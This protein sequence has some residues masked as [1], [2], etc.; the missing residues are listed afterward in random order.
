MSV[1]NENTE[2]LE[3]VVEN[4]EVETTELVECE[5]ETKKDKA[6]KTVK[7]IGKRVGKFAVITG[8]GVLGFLL[9]RS[10][11]SKTEYD[12]SEVIDVECEEVSD[13]E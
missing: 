11:A 3:E 1:K 12:N 8:V 5:K 10:S 4:K 9:G 2:K 13:E 6:V 7:K